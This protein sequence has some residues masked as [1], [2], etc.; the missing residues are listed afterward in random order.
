MTIAQRHADPLATTTLRVSGRAT[1]TPPGRAPFEARLADGRVWRRHWSE[2]D[3]LVVHF[4]GVVVV[5][6]QDNSA[7]VVFDR[8]LSEQMEQHLLLDHI[9]PLVLARAGEVVLHGGVISRSDLAAVLIGST[10]AGKSTLT[11]FAGQQGWV[12][13]GDDGA[14]VTP[15]RPPLVEPTYTTVR[16]TPAG[17]TLLGIAPETGSAVLGKMRVQQ[18]RPFQQKPVPL[19]LIALLHP[20]G[21]DHAARW[22]RVEGVE[23]HALLLGSTFHA[24]FSGSHLP[25]VVSALGSI[26]ETTRVGRLVVPRGLDGLAGAE[27][28][29]RDLLDDSGVDAADSAATPRPEA[30]S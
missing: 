26:V 7:L 17:A 29:L 24:D 1:I 28:V 5:E 15:T 9:L 20:V 25:Q 18:E 2:P 16:L 30:A 6:V 3:R 4:V 11:A 8:P 23:A 14:V 13:G 12:V 10:G 27:Q 21:A 22:E 19:L